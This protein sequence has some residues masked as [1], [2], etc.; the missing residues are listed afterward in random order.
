MIRTFLFMLVGLLL[1]G[2]A[3][4]TT[5]YVSNAGDDNQSGTSPATAWR[6]LTRAN[7][8]QYVPGDRLLLAGGQTFAGGLYLPDNTQGTPEQPIIIS[9]YGPGRAT[10]AS[11]LGAGFYGHNLGGIELRRLSFVG[12]GRLSNVS[13]GISFYLDAPQTTR[14]HLRFD[15]LDV[16]G[17]RDWGLVVGSWAG[18]SGYADVRITNCSSSANGQGGIFSYAE[19]LNAHRDWYVGNCQTFD[20]AGRADITTTNTGNG[21]VL[22]GI[23]GALIER[24]TAYNNGWLNANPGGGPVGIWGYACNRLVIQYSES[25]HNRTGTAHDGGGFDLD[26]GCTNSVIQYNYSHDNEGPG[27][28]LAQYHG[29]APMHDL[30]IRYNVSENDAR[31]HNQG[32]IQVWSSGSS[33]GIQRV[34]IHNNTVRL[35]PPANGSRP[36]AFYVSSGGISDISL[37]NNILETTGGLSVLDTQTRT[38]LRLEGNCYWS[39]ASA[40]LNMN[41]GGASYASLSAWRTGTDQEQLADGRASGLQ[42]DPLLRTGSATNGS[43]SGAPATFTTGDAT[44]VFA[45]LDNSP[46]RGAGL[47]LLAEFQLHPGPQDLAGNRTPLAPS[48][49]NI[50]AFEASTAAAQPLPVS[51]TAFTVVQQGAAGLLSWRTA[52]ERNNAYFAVEMS[53]NGHEFQTLGQVQGRGTTS[54]PQAYSF[55]D[56]HLSAYAGSRVYYRL[57]QV[58]FDQHLSY[59]PVRVLTIG[60]GLVASNLQAAPNPALAGTTVLVR[61]A[62]NSPVQLLSSQGQVVSTF[63]L[64]QEGKATLSVA[65]LAAG[66]YIIRSGS[67]SLRLLVSN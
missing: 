56:P 60:G 18:K 54:Q 30:T 32:A 21:I 2:A 22:S 31:Q 16:R 46:V 33:G 44:P 55:A 61:G 8:Q 3:R 14:R 6:S 58:D 49:G 39:G 41:W 26:G 36:K 53:L 12:A 24:C 4:A 57:R 10:I 25:H 66:M 43:G 65:G 63:Q 29:A 50:G 42:A 51:L 64:G 59:S 40:G 27:Y 19:A 23:D 17:Y 13:D 9:S 15:S 47:S 52:S 38:G 34:V 1:S 11:G 45:P 5:Y 20:N 35:T 28:L 37:R 7:A 48:R 67:H 62:A